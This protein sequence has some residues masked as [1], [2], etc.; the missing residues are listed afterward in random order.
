MTTLSLAAAHALVRE[1]LVRCGTRAPAADSVA[2]ALVGAEADGLKG[3]T[4]NPAIFDKAMGEVT[5]YDE[6]FLALAAEGDHGAVE[7]YEHLAIAA[8]WWHYRNTPTLFNVPY[9]VIL[10]EGLLM[11]SIPF[12]FRRCERAR[13]AAIPPLGV[14]QGAIM[15]AACLVAYALVG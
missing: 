10:A 11:L 9:Y 3:V 7:I 15:W 14:V 13:W 6:G 1:A 12:M 2:R 5:D 4:S 8:G